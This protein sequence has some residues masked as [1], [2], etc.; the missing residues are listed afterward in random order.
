MNY[1]LAK[2]LRD[3]GFPQDIEDHTGQKWIDSDGDISD[4]IG[5]TLDEPDCL[6]PP[7]STLIDACGRP[8][9]MLID[10]KGLVSVAGYPPIKP[11]KEGDLC[12]TRTGSTPEEALAYLWLALNEI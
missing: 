7:L 12:L 4:H 2:R 10:T 3:A 6:I 5:G 9:Q 11:D 1:E 8:I